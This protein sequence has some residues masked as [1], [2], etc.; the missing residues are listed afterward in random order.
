MHVRFCLQVY[1]CPVHIPGVLRSPKTVPDA[2]EL[3]LWMAAGYHLVLG[4]KM[5][6]LLTN[7]QSLQPPDTPVTFC[8]PLQF[9]HKNLLHF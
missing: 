4:T 9:I 6:P 5:L 3:E 7:E 1:M 8:F 2:L